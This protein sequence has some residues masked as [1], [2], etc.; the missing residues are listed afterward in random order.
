MLGDWDCKGSDPAEE[1]EATAEEQE[2]EIQ[3]TSTLPT[4]AASTRPGSPESEGGERE[5]DDF[6]VIAIY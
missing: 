5:D 2:G 4:F 3:E 6:G 1:E